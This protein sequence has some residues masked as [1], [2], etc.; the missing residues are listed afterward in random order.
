M[1]WALLGCVEPAPAPAATVAEAVVIDGA[2]GTLQAAAV[3]LSAGVAHAE[4]VRAAK[5]GPPPVSI[6]SRTSDWDLAARVAR[7]EGE[8]VLTRGAVTLRCARL[9]VRY[10][11]A[12]H[13]DRAVAE[14]GVRVTH[15]AREATADRAEVLADGGRITLTGSPALR[16]GPNRLTGDRIVLHLDDE[17]AACEGAEGRP[18]RLDVDGAA[19]P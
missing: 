13:I 12:D 2:G 4:D 3:T 17:R 11:D 7:F 8:V 5:A 14:G 9:E 10:R 19:L 16:D 15:G 1:L 18:C 6:V